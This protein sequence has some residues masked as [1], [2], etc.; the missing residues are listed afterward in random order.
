MVLTKLTLEE[1]KSRI[2]QKH[3]D[4]VIFDE[5]TYVNTR[6][7]CKFFHKEYGE[8]WAMPYKVMIGQGHPAGKSKKKKETF[9]GKYG[10][11][12]PMKHESVRNKM[13]GVGTIPIEEVKNRIYSIY[14]DDVSMDE[15]TYIGVAVKAAFTH[16]KF[17]SWSATPDSVLHGHLSVES[18]KDK[19][20]KTCVARYGVEHVAQDKDFSIKGAKSSNNSVVKFH[21][22]TGEELV[23][24]ASYESKSV[25]FLNKNQIDFEWQPK[26]FTMPSGKTY[27]PDM[28]LV[29]SNTW[30]E[31]KG[32]MRKDAQEKWDWFQSTVSNSELWNQKKLKEMGIL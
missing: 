13:V 18:A 22:K 10:V 20:K 15:S 12:H 25:D 29:E 8:W 31:I 27:R 24:Q 1:V 14:G 28:Y 16:K 11:D 2:L 21:W 26:T 5:S 30:V 32:W 17:G 9:M 6:T 7:K 23:C 19:R 3:G 4:S